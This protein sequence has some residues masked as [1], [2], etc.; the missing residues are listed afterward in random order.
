MVTWSQENDYFTWN[1][2]FPYNAKTI[3]QGL[4]IW[5]NM[6]IANDSIN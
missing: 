1:K 3:W 2:L 5:K 4:F 6:L